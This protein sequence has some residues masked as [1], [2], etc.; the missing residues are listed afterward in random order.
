[1][2]YTKTSINTGYLNSTESAAHPII[3]K[4]ATASTIKYK[5]KSKTT[6]R[7]QSDCMPHRINRKTSTKIPY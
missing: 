7:N 3:I 1:M 5:N 2:N 6:P 4:T